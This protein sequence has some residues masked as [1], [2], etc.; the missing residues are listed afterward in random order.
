M[1][2]DLVRFLLLS[3]SAAAGVALAQVA[4]D[5][6]ALRQQF[7]NEL[8]PALPQRAAPLPDAATAPLTLPD[9]ATLTVHA[10]R[11][12]G[13][14]LIAAERLRDVVRGYE[15]HPIGFADLQR[16]TLAV[17]AAYRD[18]GWIVQAWLPRQDVTEG[19]VTIRVVEARFGGARIEGP[20]PLRLSPELVL[21]E[22]QARQPVGAPLN[23]EALDRGLLLA[24]DLP[25]VAVSG[26]LESGAAD[27]ETALALRITDEPLVTGELG[28]DDGGSRSTGTERVTASLTINSPLKAGDQIRIDLADSLGS[29]F[30]RVA[31]TTPFGADGLRAGVNA[32]H[33]DYRLIGADFLA[34]HGSGSSSAWGVDFS[35]PFIRSRQRNLYASL[36][37]E[38]TVFLNRASGARQSDYAIDSLA[39]GL[40]GNQFDDLGGGGATS[41]SLTLEHGDLRQ[42]HLDPGENPALAGAYD[43]LRYGASRQQVVGDTLSFSGTLAGQYAHKGLDSSARFYLGGPAGVRAYPVNEGSGDRGELLSAELHWRLQDAFTLVGFEDWGHVADARGDNTLKGAGL[44]LVWSGPWN[45]NAQATL[46]RRIGT[47]GD[48]GAHGR[49]QDGSLDRNRFWLQARLP[50]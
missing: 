18:A 14:T 26:A 19:V 35:F 6:G 8:K 40:N 28:A 47:N 1:R 50:L 15:G 48:P 37:G 7:D 2:A 17:A 45:L 13:N 49:D 11:F 32:S 44:S 38:R 9:G 25:G 27:G 29:H 12:E 39:L 20:M 24:S 10:F 34:L 31:W 36:N 16:A 5:A 22:V 41:A 42:A 23:A 30:G 4:P 21:A 3:S 33:L 46:A 43:K